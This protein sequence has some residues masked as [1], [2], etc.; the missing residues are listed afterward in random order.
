MTAM[1]VQGEEEETQQKP[2]WLQEDGQEVGS[3]TAAN[4]GQLHLEGPTPTQPMDP[5]GA[6]DFIGLD[7]DAPGE[8]SRKH[9]LVVLHQND[10]PAGDSLKPTTK[11]NWNR[12]SMVSPSNSSV[13]TMQLP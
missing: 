12:M 2:V 4:A 5:Q 10:M 9:H 3:P 11:G 1:W 6:A 13:M 7:D 8:E